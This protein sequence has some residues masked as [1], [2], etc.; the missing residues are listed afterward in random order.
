M[1]MTTP[2]PDGPDV[3]GGQHVENA[4]RIVEQWDP[5]AWPRTPAEGDTPG[6]CRRSAPGGD[7]DEPPTEPYVPIANNATSQTAKIHATGFHHST[8]APNLARAIAVDEAAPRH[9]EQRRRKGLDHS[10]TA[11]RLLNRPGCP[12][13]R[14]S[15]RE[16]SP[17]RRLAADGL[18]RSIR[19]HGARACGSMYR[20]GHLHRREQDGSDDRR[21]RR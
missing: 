2:R 12:P 6:R 7:M 13:P 17:Q 8:A 15:H 9:F 21:G 3:G 11:E 5:G 1:S 14:T 18:S 19:L 16:V 20:C 4:E 10:P